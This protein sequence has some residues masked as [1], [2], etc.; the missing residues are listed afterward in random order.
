MMT[1][2][3]S[4]TE[5]SLIDT[6]ELEKYFHELTAQVGPLP[7][8]LEG[9]LSIGVEVF[10]LSE[11]FGIAPT[12]I[13]AL[14][15]HGVRTGYIAAQIAI[16]QQVDQNLVWQAFV[17]GVLHDIGLLIF[18]TQQ[19]QVF[20]AVVDLAQCRGQELGAIEKNLLGT[21]H[22]ESG[23]AFLARWGVP[24]DL[25][26]IVTFHDQPFQA[27][28]SGFCPLTAVYIA[29]VLE[30]GGI[31]QDGDGVVG[32]EGEAYL[33]RLG[34]WDQIPRWQGWMREISPLSV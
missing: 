28:H 11:G 33:L 7:S 6:E 15:Q 26:D 27:P 19:P 32:W 22:A 17:G 10:I 34:L 13:Q 2:D 31:A 25:L 16:S 23:T 5:L 30:G 21:T 24:Q 29:N 8:H 9:G 18:L 20:M 14:W 1:R 12:S 4:A 3:P